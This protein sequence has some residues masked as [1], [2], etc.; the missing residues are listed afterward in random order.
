MDDV[1]RKIL[2]ELQSDG[3]LT[4]T[5]LAERVRLSV[6]PCHRRLRALERSGAIAG[7]HARLD[8]LALGLGFESLVFVT[9][10]YEDRET[11]AAFEQAVADIPHVLLAQRL[12]GDPDYLL[13]VVTRDLAAYR[14][15]YDERLA[16]LPGV[17]RLS[18][19][20]VMKSVVE[21]RP[22]PL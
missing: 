13:R 14:E 19:T 17:Q 21:G 7:Y 11:V 5:E 22:L 1:D 12:F 6:S 20:L 16:T 10:R 8:P 18:S 3:R 4:L 9:M 15:L 2:A